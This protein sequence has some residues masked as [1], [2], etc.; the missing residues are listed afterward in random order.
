MT[1]QLA[2]KDAQQMQRQSRET[3]FTPED[4]ELIKKTVAK[5]ANAEEFTYFL[6]VASLRGLNP[7]LGQI[8]LNIYNKDNPNKRSVVIVTTIHGFRL[9]ADRTGRYAPGRAATYEYDDKGRVASATAYV[10]VYNRRSNTWVE[11]SDVAYWSEYNKGEN[12]WN[13]MP[14]VMLAKCAEAL[15]LRRGFPEQ[16]AG[17]YTDDEMGQ[18]ERVP[19]AGTG[20]ILE[21]QVLEQSTT[22][23]ARAEY[24]RLFGKALDL[25]V[26][27]TKDG[28]ALPPQMPVKATEAQ[29][30]AAVEYV[31]GLV[32]QAEDMQAA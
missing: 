27:L 19:N 21:G 4:V 1:A 9:I 3:V 6:R 7:L 2:T 28:K 13:T 30:A 31:R 22:T 14:R 15:A 29:V 17:M 26:E 5:D 16:L 25:G 24:A 20:E 12:L 10:K 18:A 32:L 11:Y 8:R 23:D